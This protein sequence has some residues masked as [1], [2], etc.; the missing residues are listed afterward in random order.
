MTGPILSDYLRQWVAASSPPVPWIER[1]RAKVD[2][3]QSP[4]A[5]DNWLDDALVEGID[6]L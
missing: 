3:L 4:E 5:I 6:P 1:L 2:R